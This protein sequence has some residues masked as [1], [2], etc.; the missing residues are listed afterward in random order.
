MVSPDAVEEAERHRQCE[1]AMHLDG[2]ERLQRLRERAADEKEAEA[3][4]DAAE[5]LAVALRELCAAS[6][7]L[8]AER[9]GL[10]IRCA[11]ID[12]EQERL[13]V[14]AGRLQIEAE[15]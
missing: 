1:E 15:E 13:R 9:R 2:A 8:V 7:A 5:A 4:A 12:D 11:E 14:Q 3:R 6:V 10:L